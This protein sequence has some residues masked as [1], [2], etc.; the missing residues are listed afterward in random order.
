MLRW[1]DSLHGFAG[2]IAIAAVA[3]VGSQAMADQASEADSGGPLRGS[4]EDLEPGSLEDDLGIFVPVPA[5]H[6]GRRYPATDAFPSGPD[7]GERLP[8]FTLPDQNGAPIDFHEHR[9]ASKAVVV[10]YRSAVW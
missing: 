5:S 3:L 6:P 1:K 4:L 8:E 9:G 10:F 2:L 7:V